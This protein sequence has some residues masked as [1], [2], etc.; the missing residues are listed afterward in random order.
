MIIQIET[1][2]PDYPFGTPHHHHHGAHVCTTTQP[3]NTKTTKHP[4]YTNTLHIW[5]KEDLI[6]SLASPTI[7]S[8]AVPGQLLSQL[9]D[10]P[11]FQVPTAYPCLCSS[12]PTPPQPNHLFN[13]SS[14]SISISSSSSSSSIS[15]QEL[16]CRDFS[17]RA[18]AGIF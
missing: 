17:V 15:N 14:M 10:R 8:I 9:L 7:Q 18:G 2:A 4:A 11:Q 5:H 12:P 6:D 16:L 1:L 3:P 13:C